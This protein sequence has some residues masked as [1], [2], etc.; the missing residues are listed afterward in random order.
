MLKSHASEQLPEIR[1]SKFS[2]VQSRPTRIFLKLLSSPN[3]ISKSLHCGGEGGGGTL[4]LGCCVVP[5]ATYSR[6]YYTN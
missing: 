2:Q 1:Q 4:E 3:L 6:A 5:L